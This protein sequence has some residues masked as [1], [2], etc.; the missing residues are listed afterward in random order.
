MSFMD[1]WRGRRQDDDEYESA[2]PDD[3]P[4]EEIAPAVESADE[5]AVSCVTPDELASYSGSN[6]QSSVAIAT[7]ERASTVM[8]TL[9]PL[10][11][12]A[13]QAAQEYGMAVVKFPEGVGWADLC[14]RHSG[15]EDGWKLLSNFKDGKF[16]EMAA[17]QASGASRPSARRTS[18]SRPVPSPWA[19][20]S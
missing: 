1:R 7:P 2:S 12:N 18:R 17:I 8:D 20:R 11:A 9:V 3:E 5:L 15:V 14:N 6:G 16:N 13:G 4:K 10:T 19:W